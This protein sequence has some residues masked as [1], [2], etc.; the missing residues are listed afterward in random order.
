MG[1]VTGMM[2]HREQGKEEKSKT[3][4]PSRVGKGKGGVG[5][6]IKSSQSS[7]RRPR[8][9]KEKKNYAPI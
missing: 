8:Q 6:L 2:R 9:T 5:N 4:T 3:I 7:G 1:C